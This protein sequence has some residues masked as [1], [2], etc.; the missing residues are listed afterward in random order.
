MNLAACVLLKNKN[1]PK[2]VENLHSVL[3]LLI[4]LCLKFKLKTSH[5]DT[6]DLSIGFE[7]KKKQDLNYKGLKKINH[8]NSSFHARFYSEDFFRQVEHQEKGTNG[9]GYGLTKKIKN[10][11]IVLIY[12]SMPWIDTLMQ[13]YHSY[14]YTEHQLKYHTL[15]CQLSQKL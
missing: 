3:I 6:N 12:P 11:N 9:L 7:N 2:V 15:K 10:W 14:F 13:N 1:S 4:L 8:K 5:K